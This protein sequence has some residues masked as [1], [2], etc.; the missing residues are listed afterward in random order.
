[1]KLLLLL[2]LIIISHFIFFLL[3]KSTPSHSSYAAADRLA[4]LQFKSLVSDPTGALSTWKS[5]IHFC[6]WPGITCSIR[7]SR[8]TEIV[9]NSLQLGGPIPPAIFNLSSLEILYLE[10]NNFIGPIPDEIGRLSHLW[11]MSLSYNSLSGEIPANI[12]RCSNLQFFNLRNNL[13][14]GEIPRDLHLIP[15]LQVSASG[16]NLHTNNITGR[17][18]ASIGNI[19]SLWEI[20]FTQNNLFGRIPESMS[21][22]KNLKT[23]L[24]DENMF[25]GEFPPSFFNLSLLSNI[26]LLSNG[27]EGT[28]P[29]SMFETMPN[30]QRLL[31]GMNRFHGPIPASVSNASH[32]IELDL[33]NNGFSG[34]I[35]SKLGNSQYLWTVTLGLNQLEAKEADDWRFME[36]LTNCSSLVTL[37]LQ[38]NK[39][40]GV[41]PSTLA[42]LSPGINIIALSNNRISGNLPDELGNLVNLTKFEAA[43]NLLTGRLPSSI[44]NLKNLH[45]LDLGENR[46]DGQIPDSISKLSQLNRLYLWNNMFN[47]SILASFKN[48][49]N[50]QELD[51]SGN[52]FSGEIPKEIL[53]LPSLS[54]DLDISDNMLTGKL[55]AEIGKLTNLNWFSAANNNLS[56]EIPTTLGNCLSLEHLYLQGNSFEG[57]IPQSL[58][59]LKGLR[60]LDLSHNNLVQQVPIFFENLSGLLILN[61]SFNELE[62][63]VPENGIF[64]NS[65]AVSLYGN[66]NLCGGIT[67]L[68]L[69]LCGKGTSSNL[70]GRKHLS[71]MLRI[72]IP[73]IGLV[74]CSAFGFCIFTTLCRVKRL[75]KKSS[76]NLIEDQFKRTSYAELLKA[77]DGFSSSNLIGLGGFGSVYKGVIQ[78]GETTVAIKVLDLD[79]RGASKS[80]MAECE[81]L[82]G[83]R[84]RNLVKVLTACSSADFNGRD[85]KALVLKYMHNGS[86]D[87]WLHQDGSSSTTSM[88]KFELRLSIAVDVAS[89]LD[90]LHN[91]G[92]AQIVHCDLKPSNVLLDEEMTAHLSDFGLAKILL[93]KDDKQSASI[94]IKGTIGYVPPEYGMGSQASPQGDVYSYGILLLE[95]FT[96]KRP[97]DEMFMDGLSLREYVERSYMDNLME[98][99]DPSLVKDAQT[100]VHGTRNEILE[101]LECV[102]S[103]IK[104]G[105]LCSL[106]DY[107]DRMEMG[108]VT[109]ELNAVRKA[110]EKILDQN[111]V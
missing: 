1:M 73:V 81:A 98:I 103:V 31:L 46:F 83:I 59:N 102:N 74:L 80:F 86:L 22:L 88:L 51:L 20:V 43:D 15:K 62:G 61:L 13:L 60:E 64:K 58:S 5:S 111:R 40:S 95:L 39:L 6:Q 92:H 99:M 66:K 65:T 28:L 7:G 44:G 77:T 109:V 3:C 33:E 49:V 56:G 90:Y 16:I 21:R 75:K 47:G 106:N 25:S 97:T 104:I 67:G 38:H 108:D 107:R 105:L 110:F 2:P 18:P 54:V 36:S 48:L 35:P 71:L 91:L 82:K 27:L 12:T 96:G 14:S 55:P 57:A 34:F 70:N 4:L 45:V 41:L 29:S 24:I 8:V 85:F 69:P 10:H 93:D 84:H 11:D 76:F 42:D 79:R 78:P 30:L 87:Q 37:D 53:S 94:G 100:R 32:L 101:E 68:H 26:Y 9:L 72:L 63:E 52:R 17:I 19:S 23:M 89:A 50:L